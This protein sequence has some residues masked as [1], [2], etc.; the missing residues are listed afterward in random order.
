MGDQAQ[1]TV[2]FFLPNNQTRSIARGASLSPACSASHAHGHGE[3]FKKHPTHHATHTDM[4]KMCPT[5][6]PVFLGSLKIFGRLSPAKTG[7]KGES[8]KKDDIGRNSRLRHTERHT[9]HQ[10]KHVAHAAVH[11]HLHPIRLDGGG[12]SVFSRQ[13]GKHR[14]AYE[15]TRGPPQGGSRKQEAIPPQKIRKKAASRRKHERH[16]NGHHPMP[17]LVLCIDVAQESPTTDQS[18]HVEQGDH[19]TKKY[20]ERREDC[21]LLSPCFPFRRGKLREC[22]TET[23]REP[24]ESTLQTSRKG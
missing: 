17:D 11:V 19:R 12:R 14:L 8:D 23:T 4:G 10:Q 22:S 13:E 18:E 6:E 9:P 21:S 24:L 20:P 16:P 7:E 3:H 5:L 2:L 15:Q 1:I